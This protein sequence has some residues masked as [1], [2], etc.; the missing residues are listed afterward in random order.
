MLV[1]QL[2]DRRNEHSS[3]ASIAIPLPPSDDLQTASRLTD[4]YL[5]SSM[6]LVRPTRAPKNSA[7]IKLFKVSGL[8]LTNS[9]TALFS[10][11]PSVAAL[12]ATVDLPVHPLSGAPIVAP[13]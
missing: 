8:L 4:D 11:G 3:I 5:Q 7:S 12:S 1:S 13:S 10:L 2:G 9:S 6:S